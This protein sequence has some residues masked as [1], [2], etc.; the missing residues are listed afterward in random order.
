MCMCVCVHIIRTVGLWFCIRW[1]RLYTNVHWKRRRC[2]SCVTSHSHISGTSVLV[3]HQRIKI[4]G[5]TLFIYQIFR[6]SVYLRILRRYQN[7]NKKLFSFIN[8]QTFPNNR[9]TTQQNAPKIDVCLLIPIIWISNS[10]IISIEIDK[11]SFEK[12]LIWRKLLKWR[13]INNMDFW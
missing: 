9:P 11:K 8:F 1:G 12:L 7:R 5:W 6:S 3:E 2:R 13:K 4:G 10:G